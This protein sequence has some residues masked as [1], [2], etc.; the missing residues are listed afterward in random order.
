[1][2]LPRELRRSRRP[3]VACA[4][5]LMR[6]L[7]ASGTVRASFQVYN[8]PPEIDALAEALQ[9]ARSEVGR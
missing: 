2:K 4:Q 8:S 9:A 5:P 1:M 3:P 7:G 6:R